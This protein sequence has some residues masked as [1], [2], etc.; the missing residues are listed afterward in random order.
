MADVYDPES[1]EG[2]KGP[3]FERPKE[4][5]SDTGA[6]T[7]HL[8]DSDKETA[9]K[10]RQPQA[11]SGAQNS[12]QAAEQNEINQNDA[13]ADDQV[14]SGVDVDAALEKKKKKGKAK[15]ARWKR[16]AAI[17]GAITGAIVGAA[18][19]SMPFLAGPL[20]AI[21]F[22]QSLRLPH[23]GTQER[24]SDSRFAQM[25]RLIF[26]RGVSTCNGGTCVVK[27]GGVGDSRLNYLE[28]R[29]NKSVLSE[30][31]QVGVKAYTDGTGT[32]RGYVIDSSKFPRFAGRSAEQIQAELASEGIDKVSVKQISQNGA[33]Q[34]KVIVRDDYL[35]RIGQRKLTQFV[36]K[37]TGYPDGLTTWLRARNLKKFLNVGFHPL[38]P[39][40]RAVNR[41]L[42]KAYADW[43]RERAA[44]LRGPNNPETVSVDTS[45]AKT[46][47][48]DGNGGTKTTPVD[49]S[50]P[51]A[52]ST[53]KDVSN[54]FEKVGSSTSVKATG[55]ALGALG[56]SCM[57]RAVYQGAEDINYKRNQLP[58]MN[59]AV[60]AI[61]TGGQIESQMD[62]NSLSLDFVHQTIEQ[63]VDGKVVSDAFQAKPIRENNGQTGGT[64]LTAEQKAL[65]DSSGK[66]PSYLA[67]TTEGELGNILGT[68]CDG[69]GGITQTVASVAIGVISGGLVSTAVGLI[70]GLAFGQQVIDFIANAVTGKAL[71]VANATGVQYGLYAD[72]GAYLA[73]NLVALQ[74]GAD[75]LTKT[76]AA[77]VVKEDIAYQQEDFSNHSTAYR[78]FNLGDSR[79]LASRVVDQTGAS[80]SQNLTKVT[81][82]IATIGT[83]IFRNFSALLT[84]KTFADGTSY[85]YGT[86][87]VAFTSAQLNSSLTADPFKNGDEAAKI[88][89]GGD[90]QKYID[91]IFRCKGVQL[92][93]TDTGW[94]ATAATD[95][96]FKKLIN[97][98]LDQDCYDTDSSYERIKMYVSDLGDLEAYA[99]LKGVDDTSC[100]NTGNGNTAAAYSTG[101]GG[102]ITGVSPG[103]RAQDG[104]GGYSNGKILEKNP[105]AM[106]KISAS[107]FPGNSAQA[108]DHPIATSD[109][110]SLPYLNPTAY[111]Q[112]KAL[113]EAY[114]AAHNGKGL[115][116]LS[117]YRDTKSQEKARATQGSNAAPVGKSNHGWGLAV[118]FDNMSNYDGENYKWLMQNAAKYGW[119]NP[120]N[121]WQGG[122]GPNEPWH[123]EYAGSLNLLSGTTL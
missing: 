119:S 95:E 68:L 78:L 97:G 48:S 21:H 44:K 102:V 41:K 52:T 17:G 16:P 103:E 22:A 59:L 10:E 20:E 46:S 9:D 90:G 49:N 40:D 87:K 99:C 115:L 101:T 53:S 15:G 88:L 98:H 60:E 24:T 76:Q 72:R 4:W 50:S 43:K 66:G 85:D 79:T 61:S 112:L 25:Y 39:I 93:N 55:L 114:M 84:P 11:S 89:N 14:G 12:T 111:V 70:G 2:T 58:L 13:A 74:S 113:N 37:E 121:M 83:S 108:C 92:T 19:V 36:L 91:K 1:Q 106:T 63:K 69:A 26:A 32:Y 86:P 30:L 18:T 33:G 7:D 62:F 65:V 116:L 118:D 100:D 5:N 28:R 29:V 105:T 45:N 122:S 94:E 123:W 75:P 110:P 107:D 51:P 57:A 23:F 77:E 42:N 73:S 104:W 96:A 71:D 34:V 109:V 80:P 47:E 31:G 3:D 8:Y 54:V 6:P 38:Q 64:D 56:L 120:K 27:S 82:S 35:T 67:W 117:C 81:T